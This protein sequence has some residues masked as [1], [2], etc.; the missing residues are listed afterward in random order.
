MHSRYVA[1]APSEPNAH[2][3][4]GMSY[5]WAGRFDDAM[6]E[7][8]RALQ[9]DPAF[10]V[11]VVHLGNAYFQT[12]RYRE[13]IDAYKRYIRIAPSNH[14][15]ARGY[16]LVAYVQWKRDEIEEARKAADKA[17][18]QEKNYT[19]SALMLALER[20]DA[21]SVERLKQPFFDD[22][23]VGGRGSRVS[24]RSLYF[25]R[26]YL[27]LKTGSAEE[28]IGYFNEALRLP[29]MTFDIEPLEDC[30]AN[31]YLDLGRTD[32]AIAEYE[33]VLAINP[34][35]PLAHYNLAI[36]Y[37]RK[38]E[39]EKARVNF[40]RFLEVWKGADADLPQV[41]FARHNLANDPP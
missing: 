13:A 38:G 20:G 22:S 14:E 3:S 39:R 17:I 23:L 37:E 11:A 19:G 26:G 2:D 7:Y 10:E 30:L 8:I 35:Y 25:T 40:G 1:L 31:A 21:K 41:I 16:S 18:G 24:M 9:L 34:N 32:E 12:G 33:R 6:A 27:A 29:P 5:Q 28:A 4:L 15:R 36:A